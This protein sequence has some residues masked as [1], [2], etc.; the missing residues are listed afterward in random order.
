[1]YAHKKTVKL[2]YD[3]AVVKLRDELKKEGFGVITEIDV[4]KTIKEKINIE[5]DKYVIL[6]ACNPSFAHQALLAERDLGLLLPCNVIVY[7]QNGS[8]VVASILP[9]VQMSKVGNP[10]FIPL[11]QQVETKTKE[12]HRCSLRRRI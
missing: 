2:S 11:E 1:M 4:R 10:K 7:E 9:T 3:D 5:F 8:T 6:G 12:S